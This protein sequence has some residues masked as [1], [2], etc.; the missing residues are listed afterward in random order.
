MF[1]STAAAPM[2]TGDGPTQG[3]DGPEPTD[4][5]T[6]GKQLLSC[7]SARLS[8]EVLLLD[9]CARNRINSAIGS[10]A[11]PVENVRLLPY[12]AKVGQQKW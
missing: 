12:K 2:P 7:V 9:V 5:A 11:I 6:P 1:S 4:S 8:L 3:S 10:Q